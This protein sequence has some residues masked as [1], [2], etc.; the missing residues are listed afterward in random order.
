MQVHIMLILTVTVILKFIKE[1]HCTYHVV[2]KSVK[3]QKFI[4]D[5]SRAAPLMKLC[6][7]NN[8]IVYWLLLTGKYLTLMFIIL[9]MHSLTFI[10]WKIQINVQVSRKLS[11]VYFHLLLASPKKWMV[12]KLDSPH[13]AVLFWTG[14]FLSWS[15]AGQILLVGE[16]SCSWVPCI[17]FL[18][19]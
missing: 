7:L 1:I 9:W 3:V 6:Y 17:T 10:I 8:V 2:D 18:G 13:Q 11:T 15:Q 12:A 4:T 5:G 16:P 19:L 14:V